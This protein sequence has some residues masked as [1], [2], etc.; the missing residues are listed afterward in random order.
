M[1][2]ILGVFLSLG[3]SST[4][5]GSDYPE[6]RDIK[7]VEAIKRRA[8]GFFDVLC[9]SGKN[10]IASS[11]DIRA[12]EVCGGI[13][14]YKKITC[15]GIADVVYP[16]RG[17]DGK[18]L[19]SPTTAKTCRDVAEAAVAQTVCTTSGQ[20]IWWIT[21]IEDGIRIGTQASLEECL[22]ATQTMQE[23]VVC[24]PQAPLR[25]RIVREMDLV[26]LGS[27]LDQ[28]SCIG[29]IIA[30]RE[31]VV[32]ATS[33][34]GLWDTVRIRDGKAMGRPSD[35]ASCTL[36]SRRAEAGKVCVNRGPNRWE[37][38]EINTETKVGEAVGIDACITQRTAETET[39]NQCS[40]SSICS[41]GRVVKC[42]A[43]GVRTQCDSHP[44]YVQC[45]SWNSQGNHSVDFQSC[46][47]K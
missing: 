24:A 16:T 13:S 21:R 27:T 14:S 6:S 34:P 10:E 38:T 9:R 40:I 44:N 1:R 35:F 39:K 33:G 29:A 22:F 15:T 8:D 4:G 45:Q 47:G 37:L 30:A 25:W 32:C 20:E 26:E 19:G 18:R 31:G 46:F 17:M 43:S 23:R 28:K 11:D 3:L 12:G 2:T 41:S 7:D 42:S 36:A 5:L